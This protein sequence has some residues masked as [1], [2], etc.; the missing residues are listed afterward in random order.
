MTDQITEQ[1]EPAKRTKTW[2]WALAAVAGTAV[3]AMIGL[4]TQSADSDTGT[5][6]VFDSK[7]DLETAYDGCSTT[8]MDPDSTLTLGDEGHTVTADT[9]SEYGNIA[10]LACV[11]GDIDTP[12]AIVSQMDATTAMMGAQTA[13]FEDFHYVWSY[14]PTTAST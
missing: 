14:H 10:G 13:E 6:G 7:T 8:S 12:D 9:G 4:T 3:L 5:N 2:Q 11:L 1:A